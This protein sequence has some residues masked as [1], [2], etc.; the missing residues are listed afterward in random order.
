MKFMQDDSK[1]EKFTDYR[2]NI[3]MLHDALPP[4][5]QLN[6]PYDYC[7]T[8]GKSLDPIKIEDID[9]ALS[10]YF[11][12][13][14][15]AINVLEFTTENF[16][17]FKVK[18]QN[19]L[20]F[21]SARVKKYCIRGC[22]CAQCIPPACGS[23]TSSL[24]IGSGIWAFKSGAVLLGA[25]SFAGALLTVYA[26]YLYIISTPA[27]CLPTKDAEKIN[28]IQRLLKDCKKQ[29]SRLGSKNH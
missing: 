13:S 27:D 17:S 14:E 6:M 10:D 7:C 21:F 4:L 16:Q 9:E 25:M 19:I 8:G 29:H 28:Y 22:S 24:C 18:R 1:G 20:N 15:N 26:S 5:S 12:H 23:A 11:K 2:V 3:K